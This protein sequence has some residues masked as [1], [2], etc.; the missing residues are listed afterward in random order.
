QE[1]SSAPAGQLFPGL[2]GT[3]YLDNY[4]IPYAAAKIGFGDRLACAGTY[5]DTQGAT[6]SYAVPYGPAAKV[7]EEFTVAEFGA[8]CAVFFDVG[9]GRFALLGGAFVEQF[10]YSLVAG[11]GAMDIGLDSKAYGW[12]AGF[13]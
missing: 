3:N 13:G 6:S 11:A 7:S 8:T 5:T 4:V 1:F 9:A 10:D 12:R 2:V